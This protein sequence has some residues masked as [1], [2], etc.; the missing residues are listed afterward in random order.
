MA[1]KTK[2][3]KWT[4]VTNFVVNRFSRRFSGC[5]YSKKP[6]TN[7]IAGGFLWY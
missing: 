2:I 1:V 5:R 3:E 6:P 4:D 7:C